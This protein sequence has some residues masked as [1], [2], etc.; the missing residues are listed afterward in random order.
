M[1]EASETSFV[2][3]GVNYVMESP[4]GPVLLQFRDLVLVPL[5]RLAE[6]Q[7]GADFIAKW[8][9]WFLANQAI[10]M[11]AIMMLFMFT[12]RTWVSRR[13]QRSE[14]DRA[15]RVRQAR[16]DKV[17]ADNA[18]QAAKP[19][20]IA[21]APAPVAEAEKPVSATKAKKRVSKK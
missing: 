9:D 8:G 11:Q 21:A 4:V 17:A 19:T 16:E 14:A 18:A 12:I 2:E 20:K 1:V 10:I 3:Q 7:F 15:M 5:L 13:T 6:Q